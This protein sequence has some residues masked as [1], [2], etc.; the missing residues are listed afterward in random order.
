MAKTP[1]P[2]GLKITESCQDC[3]SR[4]SNMFCGLASPTM[5]RLISIRQVSLYPAHAALFVEREEPRGF[6]ILCE[7]TA[8][9]CV[10]SKVGKRIT[11]RRVEPC[12][13][14]GLS[15]V[16]GDSPHFATAETLSACQISFF[17]KAD[18]IALTHNDPD[19]LMRVSRQ[20]SAEV[21]HA[22]NQTRLVALAPIARAKLATLLL[23]K[24]RLHGHTTTRGVRIAL[25]S[26]AE[27]VGEEIGASRETV[28]RLL[29]GLKRAGLIRIRGSAVTLT[30]IADLAAVAES[31]EA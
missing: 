27:Q 16:M 7:G 18:S 29:A 19:I 5:E 11:L 10:T 12:E 15:S 4:A 24:A 26:T 3:L 2:Y 8:R 6:F 9:L 31:G 21:H 23:S 20:L 28:T 1:T 25:N 14:L 13:T 30:R 22:W 17:P